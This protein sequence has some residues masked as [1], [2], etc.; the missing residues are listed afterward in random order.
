MVKQ[1]AS[2]EASDGTLFPNLA[3]AVSHEIKE[4]IDSWFADPLNDT[5]HIARYLQDPAKRERLRKLMDQF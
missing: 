4:E 5:R 2:Y 1:T 3:D